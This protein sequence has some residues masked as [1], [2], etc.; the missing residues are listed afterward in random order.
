V[1]IPL[2]PVAQAHETQETEVSDLGGA[3]WM[4]HI[5]IKLERESCTGF[6][7]LVTVCTIRHPIKMTVP[8]APKLHPV[9]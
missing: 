5:K 3:E 4:E 9:S 1:L 6:R 7:P 8:A 2:R